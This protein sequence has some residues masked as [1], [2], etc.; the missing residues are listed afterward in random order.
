MLPAPVIL[1]DLQVLFVTCLPVIVLVNLGLLLDLVQRP[2]DVMLRDQTTLHVLN[3]LVNATAYLAT[4]ERP[5]QTVS[6]AIGFLVDCV[7][8]VGV[9]L[10]TLQAQFVINQLGNVLVKLDILAG[11]V[12]LAPQIIT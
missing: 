12:I 6:A 4:P 7:S 1:R 10:L 8:H 9:T 2:A 5:A 3:Q 11:H